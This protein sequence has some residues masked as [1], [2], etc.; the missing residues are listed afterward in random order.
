[1]ARGRRLAEWDRTAAILAMLF[2]NNRDPK[3]EPADGYTFH[4]YRTKPERKSEPLVRM[5]LREAHR[6][7][8]HERPM[9]SRR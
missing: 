4:P 8:F 5:T 9:P 2:N 3:A 1:M 7:I 6:L